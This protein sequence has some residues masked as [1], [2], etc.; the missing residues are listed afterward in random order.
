MEG[1]TLP[2]VSCTGT[3]VDTVSLDVDV[4]TLFTD[5]TTYCSPALRCYSFPSRSRTGLDSL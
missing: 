3:L 2:L 5:S 4:L 1:A